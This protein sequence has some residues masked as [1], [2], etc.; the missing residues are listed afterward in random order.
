MAAVLAM[1][2]LAEQVQGRTPIMTPT[3]AALDE[4]AHASLAIF[5]SLWVL[6]RWGWRV[7]A[8][9]AAAAT[10]IDLDHAVVAR[11]L[12]PVAMMSI[13]TRPWLHS[14]AGVALGTILAAWIGGARLGYG[15]GVGMLTHVLRDA[16]AVPGV[17]L[18]VPFDLEPELEVPG[19][20]L[21][22]LVVVLCG[23]GLW[24][25]ARR[26]P[27]VGTRCRDD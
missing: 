9:S 6:R 22:S 12:M 23:V 4:T 21:P 25:T 24:L 10:L 15:V 26:S 5:V 16:S 11:S 17:P 1:Y 14:L 19:W 18:L 2:V 3:W 8:A 27:S 7:V 13:G 20:F